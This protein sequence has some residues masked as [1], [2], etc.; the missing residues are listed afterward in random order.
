M[1]LS[2]LQDSPAFLSCFPLM[3]CCCSIGS[4]CLASLNTALLIGLRKKHVRLKSSNKWFF[5]LTRR[6]ICRAS[7]I[8]IPFFFFKLVCVCVHILLGNNP[9]REIVWFVRVND[10]S[11]KIVKKT[12]T[13]RI[14]RQVNYSITNFFFGSL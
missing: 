6:V 12:F 2:C 10:A 4:I 3:L 14:G 1:F 5:C 8:Q 11:W 13:K 9:S 7:K